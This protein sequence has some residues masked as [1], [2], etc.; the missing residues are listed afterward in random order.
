MSYVT[1][2][3][4]RNPSAPTRE[5]FD[6][7]ASF[8]IESCNEAPKSA[9]QLR[10]AAS[11]QPDLGSL[12]HEALSAALVELTAKR[13]LYEERGKYFTLAIPEYPYL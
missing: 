1:V 3:D 2:Y 6:W 9:E 13:L 11:A 10:S 8:V 5:R 7:P 12:S 4:G